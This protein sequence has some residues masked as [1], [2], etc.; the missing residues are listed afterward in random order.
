[1]PAWSADDQRFARAIQ[2]EMGQEQKGLGLRALGVVAPPSD[3]ARQGGGSDDIGDVS[4]AVPT[5]QLFYPSN[6][7]GTPGHNWA[8]A[9]AMATPIAHKGATAGAKALALTMYDVL[10]TPQL[11]ADAWKYYREVQTKDITYE[12]FVRPQDRAPTELNANILARY[13]D[14]MRPFYYDASRYPTYLQQL[15][16]SYPTLR[17]AD[18]S[19]GVKAVP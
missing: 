4:W 12:S 3:S 19:C 16:V 15:G 11:V 2:Q 7:P 1:M 6:V 13:R 9:I 14:Q 8:D 18:G 5:V 10:T 17:G